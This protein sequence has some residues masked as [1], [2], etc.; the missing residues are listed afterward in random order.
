MTLRIAL[1]DETGECEIGGVR[2]KVVP[3][4]PVAYTAQKHLDTLSKRRANYAGMADHLYAFIEPVNAYTVPLYTAATLDLE[5]A[6]V[7]VPE[8]ANVLP[9]DRQNA[10]AAGWNRCLDA[11]GVK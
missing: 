10:F 11:L 4:E 1:I 8:R 9:T 6:A 3:V 7:R 2:C 5:A